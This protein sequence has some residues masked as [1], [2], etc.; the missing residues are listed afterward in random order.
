MGR[1]TV[2]SEVDYVADRLVGLVERLRVGVRDNGEHEYTENT[3]A[4]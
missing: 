4:I 2:Q 1:F 3:V